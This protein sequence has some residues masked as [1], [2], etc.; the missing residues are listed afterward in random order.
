MT[1]PRAPANALQQRLLDPVLNSVLRILSLVAVC[2]IALSATIVYVHLQHAN[3]GAGYTS[4]CNVS[5]RINCDRVLTSPFSAFLGV[6]VAYLAMLLYTVLALLSES[7]RRAA[8]PLRRALVAL[9][10]YAALGSLAFSLYMAV[11]SVFV[12]GTICLLC[13]GLYLAAIVTAALAVGLA[14]RQC[15]LP[16]ARGRSERASRPLSLALWFLMSCLATAAIARWTWPAGS[17]LGSAELSLEELR[18][19]DA[20]FVDWYTSLP[21]IDPS[22][23]AGH[24]MGDPGAPVTIV[25]FSDFECAYCKQNHALLEDLLE[26]RPGQVRVV[27]RHFPLDASCN[28]GVSTT[29]HH[30][31]CR[32]AEAAE[33]AADQKRFV[34]MASALFDHQKQLFDANLLRLAKSL[35]L[36][37]EAFERC[38]QSHSTLRRVVEDARAGVA[39]HVSSTPTMLINGRKVTGSLSRPDAYDIAVLIERQRLRE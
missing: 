21:I 4:F 3:S 12:L 29:L 33:C 35:G 5:A 39:I 19:I 22:S 34:E 36:D 11:V 15:S 9:I 8:E 6:P 13:S 20:D 17:Q 27:Y 32:A 25:E 16:A 30:R 24:D 28:D 2:G 14:R 18:E 26:R 1:D 7:A 37:S 23:G 38:M 10:A 31:A